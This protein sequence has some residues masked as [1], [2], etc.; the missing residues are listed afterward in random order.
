MTAKPEPDTR[1]DIDIVKQQV[2]A[3]LPD[4]RIEQLKVA[5][6]GVDDDGIWSFRRE[7]KKDEIS[8]ESSTYNVPFLVESTASEERT[9]A[10]TIE[11]AVEVVRRFFSLPYVTEGYGVPPEQ[12]VTPGQAADYVGIYVLDKEP[13][14]VM[15]LTNPFLKFGKIECWSP[16]FQCPFPAKIEPSAAKERFFQISFTGIPGKKED[17][18]GVGLCTREVVVTAIKKMFEGLNP[19]MV[20]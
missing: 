2:L 6:P 8:L 4:I 19:P 11:E 14:I 3:L 9:T 16:I 1:R 17:F 7:G 15:T 18:H 20:R 13:R 10:S 5:H 12:P